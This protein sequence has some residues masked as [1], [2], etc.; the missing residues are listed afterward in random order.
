MSSGV[1]EQTTYIMAK[2][3]QEIGTYSQPIY[4]SDSEKY[5]HEAGTRAPQIFR[6]TLLSIAIS[7]ENRSREQ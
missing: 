3:D 5:F 7:N 6:M 4:I 2:Y 1:S